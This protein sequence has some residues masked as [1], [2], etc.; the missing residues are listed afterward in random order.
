MMPR[1]AMGLLLSVGLSAC[2]FD[3]KA[4]I[5][6]LVLATA[7]SQYVPGAV[8]PATAEP[9]TQAAVT[10]TPSRG[11]GEFSSAQAIE[12]CQGNEFFGDEYVGTC[13]APGGEGYYVWIDPERVILVDRANPYLQSFQIAALSRELEQATYRAVRR[14]WPILVVTLF[15]VGTAGVSCG[16]TIVSLLS[17]VAAPSTPFWGGGCVASLAAFGA[18]AY[19]ISDDAETGAK[20]YVGFQQRDSDARYNYCRIEGGSD[21]QCR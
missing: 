14:K 1:T 16:A 21:E 12:L 10:V 18:T 17:G 11:F 4:Q 7:P 13:L 15:E 20:A 2:A 9:P 5:T 3:F 6:P 8:E 19:S